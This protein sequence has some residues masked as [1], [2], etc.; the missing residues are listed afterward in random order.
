MPKNA[1]KCQK[2]QFRFYQP[3]AVELKEVKKR[4]MRF[5]GDWKGKIGS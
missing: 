2:Y 4:T 5:C 1:K 3:M